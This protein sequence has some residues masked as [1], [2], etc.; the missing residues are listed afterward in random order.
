MLTSTLSCLSWETPPAFKAFKGVFVPTHKGVGLTAQP[1]DKNRDE[2]IQSRTLVSSLE[3]ARLWNFILSR[4]NFPGLFLRICLG[5][6]A[7]LP[8]F[9]SKSKKPEA[10][11]KF[12]SS[13]SGKSETHCNYF[14]RG[15]G[16]PTSYLI[17]GVG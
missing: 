7:S 13:S 1:K 4:A 14:S 8:L 5:R 16:P 3:M 9:P 6:E 12:P 10:R 15:K 11:R 2:V 17:S